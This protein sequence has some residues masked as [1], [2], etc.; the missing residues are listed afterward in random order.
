MILVSQKFY[1]VKMISFDENDND[2]INN[3]FTNDSRIKLYN[4][5]FPTFLYL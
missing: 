1:L 2:M 5:L 3:D 4:S